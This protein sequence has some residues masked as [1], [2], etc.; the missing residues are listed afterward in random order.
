[1][2]GLWT[3]DQHCPKTDQKAKKFVLL[4][5]LPDIGMKFQAG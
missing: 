4:K 2:L 1:M 3:N 5:E